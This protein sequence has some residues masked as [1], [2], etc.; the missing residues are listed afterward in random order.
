[1]RW[2]AARSGKLAGLVL[3]LF[4][5]QEQAQAATGCAVLSVSGVNF[6]EYNPH[7]HM[8]F[9]SVGT[10]VY[11]C[12]ASGGADTVSIELSRSRAGRFDRTMTRMG[13]SLE[14][15]LYLDPARTQVWGDGTGGTGVYRGR[16]LG[17]PVSVPVY[18]RLAPRQGLPA[19]AY[20]DSIVVTL[21]Y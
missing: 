3:A 14:Y 8:P 18:A 10:I 20:S 15:N 2:G 9:D 21:E 1:M 19:G 6:G 4:L 12:R 11:E 17:Q 5:S 7:D 16:A 13:N